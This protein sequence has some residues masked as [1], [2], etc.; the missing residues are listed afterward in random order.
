[1]SNT[2]VLRHMSQNDG[3]HQ[4][5]RADVFEILTPRLKFYDKQQLDDSNDIVEIRN[6]NWINRL[7]KFNPIESGHLS[8]KQQSV[9]IESNHAFCSRRAEAFHKHKIAQ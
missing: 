9:E 2:H 3:I 7:V 8:I 1:M 5:W 4:I 6:R